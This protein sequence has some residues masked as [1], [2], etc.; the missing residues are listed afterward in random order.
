VQI[1]KLGNSPLEVSALGL[2]TGERRGGTNSR[3]DHIKAVAD[4][5]LKRLKTDRIDI[6]KFRISAYRKRL[7][8]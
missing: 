5:S 8:K 6:S 1:R 4:A 3:P 2:A 7:S